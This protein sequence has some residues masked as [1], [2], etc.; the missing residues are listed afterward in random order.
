[1]KTTATYFQRIFRKLKSLGF[2]LESDPKL[3]SVATMITGG[4]LR[5]SWWAHPLGQEI[6]QVNERL[7]DHKDVLIMKL[8]SGKVTFV[9][10]KV[11]SQVFAIGTA[12]ETWQLKKPSAEAEALL[13]QIDDSG[14]LTT[15]DVLKSL[16]WTMKLGDVARELEKRLLVVGTQF[17]SASGAHEKRLET[18][19]HWAQRVKFVPASVSV[20]MAK[21]NLEDRLQAL[22]LEF[23]AKAKF[24][25]Q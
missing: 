19:E 13:K 18:W 16:K 20:A 24:P 25:W 8:I 6:F 2:L 9:H 3:P 7:D 11:W 1:M 21:T 23:N 5:G 17:H 10:R 15:A 12:R 4:P 14:S 22:N